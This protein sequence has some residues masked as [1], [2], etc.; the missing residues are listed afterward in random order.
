MEM[1]RESVLAIEGINFVIRVVDQGFLLQRGSH[2]LA[3]SQD[4]THIHS[5][6]AQKFTED[7]VDAGFVYK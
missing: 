4:L 1:E 5:Q 7:S 6:L 2:E 3:A